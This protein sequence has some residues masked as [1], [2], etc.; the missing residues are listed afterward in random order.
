VLR[1]GPPGYEYIS[2]FFDAAMDKIGQILKDSKMASISIQNAL[3]NRTT[4]P[5]GH[6][7]PIC[8]ATLVFGTPFCCLGGGIY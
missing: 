4:V 3:A 2:R 5:G 1:K 7:G 6:F 8:S